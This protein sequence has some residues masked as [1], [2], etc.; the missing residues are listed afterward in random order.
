LEE[1][2]QVQG[3]AQLLA[4]GGFVEMPMDEQEHSLIQLERCVGRLVIAAGTDAKQVKQNLE[5]R[6]AQMMSRAQQ[7]NRIRLGRLSGKFDAEELKTRQDLEAGF[8]LTLP[9]MSDTQIIAFTLRAQMGAQVVNDEIQLRKSRVLERLHR[10]NQAQLESKSALCDFEMR[11][12]MAQVEASGGKMEIT[13]E[14]PAEAAHEGDSL[15]VLTGFEDVLR[16]E[17]S[18]KMT[19]PT[20]AGNDG[21]DTENTSAAAE[22]DAK[23]VRQAGQAGNDG[24]DAVNA[25]TAEDE[26]SA[27]E[28]EAKG[29]AEAKEKADAKAKADA[30]VQADKEEAEAKLIEEKQKQEKEV[31]LAAQKNLLADQRKALETAL[32]DTNNSDQFV[33]V[34]S[35]LTVMLEND[36]CDS[37][38]SEKE[39]VSRAR[40]D[41]ETLHRLWLLKKAV[42]DLNQ[43][44]I[45]EIKSFNEPL[46]EV[47]VVM[48]V[49]FLLL[50]QSRNELSEWKQIR[51]WIGKTGKF[52]L[53]RRIANFTVPNG[54]FGIK[55]S[56]VKFATDEISMVHIDRI[57]DISIGAMVF[58]S[59]ASGVLDELHVLQD[60]K[61]K[62]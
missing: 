8:E 55:E 27:E 52:S 25:S 6:H 51:T 17:I 16:V 12:V 58:Y 33:V 19:I 40:V 29:A 14:L 49:V 13:L 36:L 34:S 1:A 61:D 9:S 21:A 45:A 26:K 50:G 22:E 56:T 39:L 38:G 62:K 18:S 30:K 42:A 28:T 48:R 57:Q 47:I 53:K 2:I 32:E 37:T 10:R 11:E 15:D 46:Q 20:E 23:K 31:A 54:E 60:K 35:A 5:E 24:E 59:W 3:H 41:L 7:R 4:G 44:T 43:K